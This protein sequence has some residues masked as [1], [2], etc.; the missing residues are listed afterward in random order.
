MSTIDNFGRNFGKSNKT[1]A[2]FL[3]AVME[4]EEGATFWIMSATESRE[5]T[6]TKIV[7][8]DLSEYE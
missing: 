1:A 6:L 3:N 2:A 8:S 5:L 7:A 4:A